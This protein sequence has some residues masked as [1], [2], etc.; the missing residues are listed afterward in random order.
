MINIYY[1]IELN[2]TQ[3]SYKLTLMISNFK[4]VKQTQRKKEKKTKSDLW[5]KFDN[6]IGSPDDESLECLYTNQK[7]G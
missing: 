2:I 6:M 5:D 1:K 7:L 3:L 4:R